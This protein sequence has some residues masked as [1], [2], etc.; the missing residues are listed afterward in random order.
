[1]NDTNNGMNMQR[2]YKDTVFRML[3]SEKENLLSLYNALNGTSYT[4]PDGLIITT[5]ENAVYMN[6]KNDISFVLDME[7]MLYEHQSTVNPNMPLRSLFYVTRVIQ[8]ITRE[9]DLYG[10]KQVKIPAPRFI[11]FY[12]GAEPQP[13]RQT[14]R[15]SDAFE[16]T[17]SDGGRKPGELAGGDLE[18]MVTVYNI[19]LGYNQNIMEGCQILKEY[20]QY[21]SQVRKYAKEMA[22]PEAVET[23]V[24]YCINNRILADFLARN[25]AEAIAVSIFEYD[26]EKHI[27]N[28][29]EL[30]YQEGRK[31]GI[32]TGMAENLIK[33]VSSLMNNLGLNLQ[34]ACESLG[35][36]VGEYEDAK[37]KIAHQ[38]KNTMV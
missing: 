23:A 21:V 3:F 12:N 28:E 30:S 33:S 1:M 24:D 20:A 5:L 35:I 19:N 2:N 37:E 36:T 6:Y 15:L 9:K 8:G 26:E 27:R 10:R 32:E 7:L 22:F 31:S 11:V 18:L 29:K 16:G 38:E 25:R 34:K 17:L 13:E 14:L 4:D